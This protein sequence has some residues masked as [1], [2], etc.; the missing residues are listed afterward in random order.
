LCKFD[1]KTEVLSFLFEVKEE[2][3]IRI[4]CIDIDKNGVIW[5]ALRNDG[6][7]CYNPQTNETTKLNEYLPKPITKVMSV[8]ADS[9]GSIWL[10][11][12]AGLAKY[13]PLN[14]SLVLLGLEKGLKNVNCQWLEVDKIDN[15]WI[16]TENG[17]F[18]YLP[19][20]QKFE[21]Y[22]E[23]MGLPPGKTSNNLTLVK[24][25]IWLA[26]LGA[27]TYWNPYLLNT[28]LRCVP[29][30]ISG[31]KIFDHPKIIEAD[32]TVLHPFLL[33]YDQKSITFEFTCPD[34]TA[35]EQITF[36][37][38]LENFSK[39]WSVPSTARMATFT[40]L[41]SGDYIFKVNAINAKGIKTPIPAQFRF[42]IKPPFW[43]WWSFRIIMA[44]V[45][46]GALRYFVNARL[47]KFRLENTIERQ[48]TEMQK[49]EAIYQKDVSEVA[50]MALKAQ[51]NPHFIFNAL[52]SINQYTQAN[53]PEKASHYLTRFAKLIRMMLNQSN[54]KL[55]TLTEEL[56]LLELYSEMESLR[57]GNRVTTHIEVA[58]NLEQDNIEIPPML[59]Q[60][61]IENAFLHG[62][63]HKPEPGL[64]SI[65]VSQTTDELLK[66]EITD[67]G[68]GRAKA[69]EIRSGESEKKL[70]LGT[71][72]SADRLRLMQEMYQKEATV[73]FE[74]LKDAQN[75]GIGT[76]VT[77]LLPM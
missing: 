4:R 26:S 45:F 53:A 69:L 35:S 41:A 62:F 13:N 64:L 47:R 19:D 21:I 1:T 46:L 59:L 3:Y 33:E 52:N 30:K 16:C 36:E 66:I 31:L 17:V 37:Y 71:R 20:S 73:H 28:N 50:L 14:H 25:E 72:I 24:N 56:H 43:E 8:K 15:I 39:K 34:F 58:P 44:C 32:S 9:K 61:Y 10:A 29:A 18:R 76:L 77:V 27:L 2:D 11:T 12:D 70:S 60:P 54:Q 38:F 51:M 23:L 22:D 7:L 5:A 48:K 65:K 55:I 68:I 49:K 75:M 74:D 57:L 6:F 40:N 67:N 63:R 42:R